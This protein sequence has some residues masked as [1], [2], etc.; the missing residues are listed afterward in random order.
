MDITSKGSYPASALSNFSPHSFIISGVE[1]ASMEG[2]L[3]SLK[4]DETNIQREV[5]KLVGNEAKKRGQE[6]DAEWKYWQRLWWAGVPYNRSSSQYQTLINCA[7]ERLANNTFFQK[8]LL[9]S[10]DNILT[11]SI[12]KS[13]VTDTIL[14]EK[15]FCSRLIIIRTHL[16]SKKKGVVSGAKRLFQDLEMA[17]CGIW[18]FLE[19]KE[20]LLENAYV[21]KKLLKR[22]DIFVQPS[23]DI[24][25]LNED[26]KIKTFTFYQ[27][28]DSLSVMIEKLAFKESI[29]IGATIRHD[30]IY[31]ITRT[32]E[33]ILKDQTGLNIEVN[34]CFDYY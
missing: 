5:C 15:E 32:L 6:E 2:F 31:L 25:N 16:Q 23:V 22:A 20:E 12:G 14:T 19:W 13:D 24:F 1:C 27:K 8:A 28:H 29:L 3:Q 10:G 9:D 34:L 11:H 18:E 21:K 4:F 30:D 33:K 26:F 7:F 17:S